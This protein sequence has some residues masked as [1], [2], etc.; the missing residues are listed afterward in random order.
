M[1]CPS[2]TGSPEWREWRNG[3]CNESIKSSPAVEV[4]CAERT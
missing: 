3:L 4:F 2:D 1:V